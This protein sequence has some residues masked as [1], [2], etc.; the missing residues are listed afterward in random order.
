[1]KTQV[2]LARLVSLSVAVLLI[3]GCSSQNTM[4]KEYP[5]S[6]KLTVRNPVDVART[7]APVTLEI[8][9]I[10]EHVPNF[11]PEA[12]VGLSAGTEI[13]G[14]Y[15]SENPAR[16]IFTMDF[17]SGESKSLV[18]RY[19]ESGGKQRN[20]TKRTQAVLAHK[21]GGEWSTEEQIYEGG[22]FTE[23]QQVNVP[24]PHT[25]HSTYFQF[26]GPG[27][28]SDI[29]GYRL[30]LDHRNAIDIFGK[31]TTD[32][33]LDSVGTEDFGSYHEMSDWGMDILKVGEAYGLGAV[34]LWM[35]GEPHKVAEVDDITCTVTA[36]GP[37]YSEIRLDYNGWNVQ[38]EKY[39]MSSRL[40]I[41]A[42]CRLTKHRVEVSENVD[43][44]SASI[45]NHENT[46]FLESNVAESGWQYIATYGPQDI[47]GR[48]LGMVL[49]YKTAQAREIVPTDLDY[50]VVIEPE[51]N[52]TS[53]YFGAAW[54]EEPDG[55][56]TLEEF[57]TYLD[58]TRQQLNSPIIV[59]FNNTS[60]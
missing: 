26:E 13:P 56:A 15:I 19:A 16:V 48:D 51:E 53:W 39:N 55:I 60:E 50:Y 10:K 25:D 31:K 47:E 7:D 21:V 17:Q 9:E 22:D 11:N 24:D 18:I 44:L 5:E 43:M 49:F 35:N 54:A 58:V 59:E 30:Y 46:E 20:Y 12:V 45:V 1:M 28:E 38:D 6:V 36:N 23:V 34:G 14:Q 8:E 42:G 40:G 2:N 57:K 37:V 27:W 41:Y 52:S 33:V 4:E 29:V 3:L 32:M